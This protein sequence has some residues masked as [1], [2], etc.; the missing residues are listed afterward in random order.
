MR[1]LFVFITLFM[2]FNSIAQSK[3]E[4]IAILTNRLD[5]VQQKFDLNISL[6]S[7]KVKNLNLENIALNEELEKAQNQ[8]QVESEI[9]IEKEKS[10]RTLNQQNLALIKESERIKNAIKDIKLMQSKYL[11]IAPKHSA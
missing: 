5:S 4:Q 8:L 6:L 7:K 2:S 11:N 10:I 3:K 1:Y 9:I